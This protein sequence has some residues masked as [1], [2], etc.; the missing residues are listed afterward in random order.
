MKL[1]FNYI[2]KN[3]YI[4]L[5]SFSCIVVGMIKTTMVDWSRLYI[6]EFWSVSP[7]A[8]NYWLY[9]GTLLG[10]LVAGW[11]SDKF[12]RP[13][14]ANVLFHLGMIFLLLIF[15]LIRATI[16]VHWYSYLVYSMYFFTVGLQVLIFITAVELSHKKTRGAVVGFIMLLYFAAPGLSNIPIGMAIQNFGWNYF[17]AILCG[18]ATLSALGIWCCYP[19]DH[20]IKIVH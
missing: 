19:K 11:C 9:T 8:E 5:L 15:W 18:S 7:K 4:W 2:F 6:S 20:L 1:F 14:V 13:W 10:F 12:Y 17:F 3:R 16:I